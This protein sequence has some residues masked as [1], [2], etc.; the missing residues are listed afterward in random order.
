MKNFFAN[1]QR[2]T[3]GELSIDAKILYSKLKTINMGEG[4]TYQQLGELISRKV[5]GST[6]ALIRARELALRD[7]RIV[8]RCEIKT[9]LI[10]LNDAEITAIESVSPSKRIRSII[11]KS[12]KKISC[13]DE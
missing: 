12:T 10:R 7:D 9:G 5:D 3:P 4:I 8:F 6:T 2:I 11:K 1:G 13:V